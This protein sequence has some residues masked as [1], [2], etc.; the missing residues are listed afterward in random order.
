[1]ILDLKTE[2]THTSCSGHDR[3]GC[4]TDCFTL[5]TENALGGKV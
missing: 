4:F 3:K 2:Q 5:A 1:M